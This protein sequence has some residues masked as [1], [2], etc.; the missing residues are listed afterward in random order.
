MIEE[1]LCAELHECN[2]QRNGIDI[3]FV[4][5]VLMTEAPALGWSLDPSNG[6]LQVKFCFCFKLL[7]RAREPKSHVVLLPRKFRKIAD[8]KMHNARVAYKRVLLFLHALLASKK[9]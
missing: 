6:Y 2:Y 3:L 1:L 9:A 4:Y 5:F 7:S 8:K